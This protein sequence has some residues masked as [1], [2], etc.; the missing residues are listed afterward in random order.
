MCPGRKPQL[1]VPS[2][3]EERET[4]KTLEETVLDLVSPTLLRI[5]LGAA[6]I[7]LPP[8]RMCSMKPDANKRN[9]P[10]ALSMAICK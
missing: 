4:E 5:G 10:H 8:G 2:T 6:A 9:L 3:A 1:F 7:K